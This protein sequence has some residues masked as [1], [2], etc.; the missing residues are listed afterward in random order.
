MLISDSNSMI[1][2]S[3]PH[4]IDIPYIVSKERPECTSP[5]DSFTAESVHLKLQSD[6]M[7]Y[8][9]DC[10]ENEGELNYQSEF[11]KNNDIPQKYEEKKK[12]SRLLTYHDPI[13]NI[14]LSALDV[15]LRKFKLWIHHKIFDTSIYAVEHAPIHGSNPPKPT[16]I[17]STYISINELP[18]LDSATRSELRKLWHARQLISDRTEVLSVY[19]SDR[20]QQD[21]KNNNPILP[22]E[23]DSNVSD[24]NIQRGGFSDLLTVHAERLVCIIQDEVEDENSDSGKRRW[25]LEWLDVHYGKQETNEILA[26]NLIYKS[27]HIQRLVF[28]NFLDW[29]RQTFPYYYDRCDHCGASAREDECNEEV[30]EEESLMEMSNI[31]MSENQ[32]LD[33]EESEE[34]ENTGSF[35]GYVY[36][37]EEE[38][39]GKASRTELYFCQ[40]CG[41]FTRFPRYNTV[42]SILGYHKG[43]CGEYSMLLFRFLRA[44][45]HDARWVVDWAD[46]V[47]AETKLNGRWVHLDPCE[48]AVDKP[49]LYEEWGK[50]QTYI[51]AFHA[52]LLT[53][54]NSL[55]NGEDSLP[56]IG[57]SG[58][59]DVPLIE[60]VTNQY[61]SDSYGKIRKRREESDDFIEKALGSVQ[62]RIRMTLVRSGII[63]QQFY[64]H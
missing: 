12:P 55:L 46:H 8:G 62:S 60:D 27:E 56:G 42:K 19:P 33:E 1:P 50:K 38:L 53:D 16:Q 7:A 40:K 10:P 13:R 61:T 59:V 3:S 22:D 47:W 63:S 15:S 4:D 9:S 29:F 18:V 43:R 23:G 64:P 24:S 21:D 28:Q 39:L 32:H 52:P 25:L 41:S 36:P 51:L 30:V 58:D 57:A 6:Q 5:N 11:E 31:F 26:E 35:L 48:A 45:G 34:E 14:T 37:S 17:N 54:T 20:S 44:L 2:D 49:L